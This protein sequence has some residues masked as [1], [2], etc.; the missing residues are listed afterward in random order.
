[1]ARRSDHNR[2]EL[3]QLILSA[4][5]SIVNERGRDALTARSVSK[6]TG[7][8]PGTIYNVYGSMDGLI[9]YINAQTMDIL[10]EVLLKTPEITKPNAVTKNLL[11]LAVSY[12]KFVT[13]NKNIWL[14][15]FDTSLPEDRVTLDWYQSKVDQ[16]FELIENILLPLFAQKKSRELHLASRIL[17]SSFHGFCYLEEKGQFRTVSSKLTSTDMI[18]FLIENFVVGLENKNDAKSP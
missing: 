12:R 4:A 2:E 14:L 3:Q 13:N 16:L 5:T 15:L 1:L 11:A 7:Y 10:Y 8:A 9:M 6:K 18:E 17:W